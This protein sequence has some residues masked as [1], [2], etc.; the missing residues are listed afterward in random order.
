MKWQLNVLALKLDDL[1]SIPASCPL[2]SM[3]TI[4]VTQALIFANVPVFLIPGLLWFSQTSKRHQS[5]PYFLCALVD[6]LEVGTGYLPTFF[7]T[8]LSL[9]L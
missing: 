2:N 9:F 6:R 7:S 4:A 1:S 3:H 8:L 5:N